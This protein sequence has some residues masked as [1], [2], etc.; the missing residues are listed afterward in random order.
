M[1]TLPDDPQDWSDEQWLAWLAEGD[2]EEQAKPDTS[3]ES[4]LP[5]WR[6]GPIAAQFLAA[7]MLGV[8]EV[9]YGPKEEP[10]IIAEAPGEPPGDDGFE[11]HLDPDKPDESV[12][13]VRPWLLRA[14][15]TDTHERR[16]NSADQ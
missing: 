1:A 10:A 13:L 6:K 2:A 16:S 11:V 9:L 7:S 14:V 8:A 3:D 5:S 12:I 15:D 4:R